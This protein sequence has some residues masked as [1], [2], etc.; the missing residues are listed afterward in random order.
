MK[1]KF[2][3]HERWAYA[4]P[5][6]NRELRRFDSA[7]HKYRRDKRGTTSPNDVCGYDR[8]LYR[9]TDWDRFLVM[10]RG[11]YLVRGIHLAIASRRKL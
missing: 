11:R 10:Y 2:D 8:E 3:R 5:S 6:L 1:K 7:R 9:C 4:I